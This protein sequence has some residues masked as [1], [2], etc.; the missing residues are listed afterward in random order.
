MSHPL[1]KIS[2]N[3]SQS[4]TGGARE[5]K[6][7]D[8]IHPTLCIMCH[9]SPVTCHLSRGTCHVSCVMCHLSHVKKQKR[10]NFFFTKQ[11]QKNI[12][13]FKNLDKT[14]ELV[15][16]GSVINKYTAVRCSRQGLFPGHRFLW[17]HQPA[18]DDLT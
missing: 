4:Q 17:L 6:Y 8:N 12:L 9:G 1:V 5:L 18:V 2:S 3:Y 15:G 11:K 16:G 7:R 13:S 14:M 10:L